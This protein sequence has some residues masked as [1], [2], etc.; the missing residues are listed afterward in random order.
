MS[1]W[2]EYAQAYQFRPERSAGP[3]GSLRIDDVLECVILR[4]DWYWP[5]ITGGKLEPG[6]CAGVPVPGYHCPACRATFFAAELAEIQK[7]NCE[8]EKARWE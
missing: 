5:I 1:A 8:E 2:P 7:H 6:V 3:L 4:R